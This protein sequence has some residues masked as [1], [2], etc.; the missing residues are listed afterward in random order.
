MVCTGW[1]NDRVVLIV[2]CG[3]GAVSEL[4][5]I[6]PDFSD[7]LA[8]HDADGMCGSKAGHNAAAPL[9]YRLAED[10]KGPVGDRLR[11]AAAIVGYC[12][13]PSPNDCECW[14]CEKRQLQV[15]NRPRG[16]SCSVCD[17]CAGCCA[18]CGLCKVVCAGCRWCDDWNC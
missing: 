16:D 9:T 6:Y 17:S 4:G 13:Q 8:R 14:L 11:R 10:A 2:E 15:H 18:K 3:P 1:F 5:K 7:A 12:A